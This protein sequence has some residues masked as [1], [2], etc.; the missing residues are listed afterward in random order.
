M[1]WCGLVIS[2][3]ILSSA[4]TGQEDL[5]SILEEEVTAE[6][7][8]AIFKTTRII[9][10]H[11][12]EN[13]PHRILDIK[14][15]HRFGFLKNGIYDLFG[16]DG[17]T[18][19]LGADYGLTPK[20][21]IGFGR[22]TLEKVY[23]GYIKYKLITQQ[24]GLRHI[25]INLSY[26]G[27]ASVRTLRI[28]DPNASDLFSSRWFYTH[29]LLLARKFSESFSMQLMPT[30][31]HRNLVQTNAEKNDV[32]AIG[33]GGRQ[34][35]SKRVSI[36]FE[37]FYVLPDQLTDRYKN[38]LSFGF[39]IETGGHVFQLHFTNSTAMIEKGFVAETLGDWGEGEI[40]FGFNISR[41]FSL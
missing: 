20:L 37:Y 27:T 25:P 4:A 18:I 35:L 7:V 2:F 28:E 23:D 26:V 24:T 40:H 14:I 12:I 9:N 31:V 8:K 22:S 1:R 36:N 41:V 39:D 30:F 19:R 10:G 6:E 32:Y 29:Q 11:S 38:S 17:A 15:S 13:T 34:K 3:L 21:T 16:L 33:I 5:L